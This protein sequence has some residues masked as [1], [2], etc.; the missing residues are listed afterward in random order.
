M[1]LEFPRLNRRRPRLLAALSPKRS[2]QGDRA[3]IEFLAS[4]GAIG[5]DRAIHGVAS[6]ATVKFCVFTKLLDGLFLLRREIEPLGMVVIPPLEMA[7]AEL[8]LGV[9]L[10]AGALAGLLLFDLKSHV[11]HFSLVAEVPR[12]RDRQSGLEDLPA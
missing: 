11:A 10:V 6:L 1:L 5:R 12:V 3:R 4:G 9:F 7:E 8:P 2:P